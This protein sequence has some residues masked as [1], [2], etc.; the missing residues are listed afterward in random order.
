MFSCYLLYL[1]W[2]I[3]TG[4]KKP[5]IGLAEDHWI[6]ALLGMFFYGA[7]GIYVMVTGIYP[8]WGLRSEVFRG[9]NYPPAARTD[10]HRRRDQ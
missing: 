3:L 10:V 1:V 4:F 6:N 9:A 5:Y 7:P 8:K 2:E